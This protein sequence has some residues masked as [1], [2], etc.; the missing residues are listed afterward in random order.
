MTPTD[1][2]IFLNCLFGT[3]NI[4]KNSDEE[5]YMYFG[6]R[7]TFDSGGPRSFENYTARNAI[8]FGVHN[9]SLSNADNCKNNFVVQDESPTF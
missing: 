8:V 4:V 2:F 6:Y 5:K 9:I 1:N 7:I 3:I